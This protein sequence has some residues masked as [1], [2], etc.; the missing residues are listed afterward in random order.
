V[1]LLGMPHAP[2]LLCLCVPEIAVGV[3]S[4]PVL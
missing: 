1:L 3:T 2:R 4:Y